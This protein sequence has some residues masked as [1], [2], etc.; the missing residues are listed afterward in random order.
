MTLGTN[1][2]QIVFETNNPRFNCN[3]GDKKPTDCP[4]GEGLI[5]EGPYGPDPINVFNAMGKHVGYSWNYGDSVELD[6]N[7][8]NTVLA[9]RPDQ[10]DELEMY[11]SD[12]EIEINFI[13]IRGEVDYTFYVPAALI[14][15]L[16][17]NTDEENFIARNTYTCTA[18]LINPKDLSRINLFRAPYKV[19]VK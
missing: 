8:Q 9:V 11:L 17:L 13:D 19:Y 3:M 14:T 10:V 12:K 2:N 1:E 15:K 5:P 18:V 7:I 16:R 4:C 6:I